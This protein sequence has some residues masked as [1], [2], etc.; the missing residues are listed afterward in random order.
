MLVLMFDQ[1]NQTCW[2]EKAQEVGKSLCS[3]RFKLAVAGRK[4][5]QMIVGRVAAK[6]NVFR[7]TIQYITIQYNKFILTLNCIINL[8]QN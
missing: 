8:P 6:P 2:G 5:N 1:D 3:R 4:K 7:V